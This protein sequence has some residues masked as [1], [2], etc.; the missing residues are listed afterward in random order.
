MEIRVDL[1]LL[2]IAETLEDQL[3]VLRERGGNRVL[4]IRIGLPEAM[5]I[6]RGVHGNQ[7]KRPMTHDLLLTVIDA[8]GGELERIVICDLQDNAFIAKLVIR[9]NGRLHEIDSRPS[10]AIAL[11]FAHDTPIFVESSVL[12]AAG[13]TAA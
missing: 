3:I 10:D 5:A 2:R 12:N 7:A 13:Q 4:H 8:L 9:Q 6:Q 11:S 1:T